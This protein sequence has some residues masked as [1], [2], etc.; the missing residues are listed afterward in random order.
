[1]AIVGTRLENILWD[2]Y[3]GACIASFGKRQWSYFHPSTTKS[4][5]HFG[6]EPG[7]PPPLP[8]MLS[9]SKADEGMTPRSGGIL[10]SFVSERDEL[11]VFFDKFQDP[12]WE[13]ALLAI[14][15]TLRP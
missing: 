9:G 12:I 5:L 2:T 10:P 6:S 8:A 14:A 3:K 11:T 4:P 13:T 7:I 15:Q 1:M